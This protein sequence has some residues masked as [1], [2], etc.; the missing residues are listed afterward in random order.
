[1]EKRNFPLSLE[2]FKSSKSGFP[3][4]VTSMEKDNDI[5]IGN[6]KSLVELIFSVAEEENLS[7]SNAHTLVRY[8]A[9][10]ATPIMQ[11]WLKEGASPVKDVWLAE[12]L[13]PALKYILKGTMACNNVKKFLY[14]S[15]TNVADIY[16][17]TIKTI[18]TEINIRNKISKKVSEERQTLEEFYNK[19]CLW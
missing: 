3:N 6:E 4:F 15:F 11:D 17:L 13:F 8:C 16:P 7:K 14:E 18:Y 10:L 2:D 19:L 1:M 12:K 9:L 5:L